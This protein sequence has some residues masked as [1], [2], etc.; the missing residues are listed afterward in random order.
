MNEIDR[1][2]DIGTLL[3]RLE[4]CHE[5]ANGSVWTETRKFPWPRNMPAEYDSYIC[6]GPLRSKV[7]L[8]ALRDPSIGTTAIMQRCRLKKHRFYRVARPQDPLRHAAKVDPAQ[9]MWPCG[10]VVEVEAVDIDG[11]VTSPP[12][13]PP[14]A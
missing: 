6:A 13:H 5:F 2:V 9:A 4:H 14:G 11:G 8:V 7:E 1:K 10:A 3:R 12:P